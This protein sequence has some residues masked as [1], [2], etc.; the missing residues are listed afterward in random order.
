MYEM[1]ILIKASALKEDLIEIIESSPINFNSSVILKSFIIFS[2]V[3]ILLINSSI[4]R[5]EQ[6]T[7]LH[8]I[9]GLYIHKGRCQGRKQKSV[10]TYN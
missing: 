4:I 3:V 2:A 1:K 9:T 7:S 5:W 10:H 8:E 6:I